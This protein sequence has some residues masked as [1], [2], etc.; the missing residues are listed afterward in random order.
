M[1]LIIKRKIY[2]WIDQSFECLQYN[3]KYIDKIEKSMIENC[4]K[5]INWKE[6]RS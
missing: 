2:L 1:S 4:E 3:C 5:V 6:C